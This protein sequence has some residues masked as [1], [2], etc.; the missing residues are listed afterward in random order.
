MIRAAA[1]ALIGVLASALLLALF[2][3]AGSGIRVGFDGNPPRLVYGFYP[4]ERDRGSGLTFAW[5]GAEAG[6]RLPGLDRRV[7]WTLTLRVRGARPDRQSN[8]VLTFFADGILLS[9]Y[10][11]TTGFEDLSV[12]VPP[13]PDRR[14]VT[15]L[16]RSSSTFVPST[17]DRRQ[18]GVLVDSLDV[19]AGRARPAPRRGAR[20]SHALRG[21]V[22]CVG[23]CTW[24]HSRLRDWRRRRAE[25][26]RGS[27]ARTRVRCLHELPWHRRPPVSGRLS[28][29]RADRRI[30]AVAGFAATQHGSLCNRVRGR[31]LPPQAAG[32]A[33]SGHADRRCALPC[34]PLSG[35]ARRPL[36]LHVGRPRR[37]RVSLRAGTV[38]GGVSVRRTRA[39]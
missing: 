20:L 4:A 5:T 28:G 22:G 12:V 8:P 16:I 6:L 24:R 25:R 11:T 32:A 37:L 17:A 35:R 7:A 14:G 1:A 3:L 39:R 27:Y 23:R 26:G 15:I 34:P 9:T 19:D 33:A 38:R 30:P 10:Q 29:A 13:R 36:L 18:L 31:R 2:T 21:R